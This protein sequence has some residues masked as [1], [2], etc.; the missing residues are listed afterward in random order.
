[1]TGQVDLMKKEL[2]LT[3]REFT[4]YEISGQFHF[5]EFFSYFQCEKFCGSVTVAGC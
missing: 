4:D 2:L 3:L 1:M 5:C